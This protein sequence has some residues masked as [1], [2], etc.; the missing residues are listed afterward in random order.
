MSAEAVV[1]P[2]ARATRR[3]GVGT[4][5]RWELRKLV[6][7]KRTFIG[8][9]AAVA[10]PLIFVIALL[11]DPAGGPEGVPFGGAV[12]ES[13]LA[14]PLVCMFFGSLWLIPLITALVA[15]DIVATE[16][17]HGTLKTILTRSVERRQVFAGKA[18]AAVTYAAVALT[19]YVGVSLLAGG[20][21]WGFD[22]VTSLSGTRVDTGRGLALI[23]LGTL[24][25][26]LPI[27]ALTGIALLLSTVTRNSAAAVVGTL[28]TSIVLQL[29]GVIAALDFLHPYLL[30]EQ[31][32]A[33]QG[34]LREPIDW[35]PVLRAAWVSAVWGLPALAVAFTA[36]VRR[37]VAGG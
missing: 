10:V 5:Y 34:L 13:G 11:A 9:G 37:D 35:A 3:P 12:R 32:D 24:V 36:F 15:G 31:F 33:W 7:Q 23:A 20:V 1:L 25:Y 27:L 26:F 18:L 16:D 29:L 14:V 22:P 8:L 30:T 17:H 6:A 21:L 19:A 4:V 2:R 28:M